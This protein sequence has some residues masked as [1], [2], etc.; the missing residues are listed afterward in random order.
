MNI[1]WDNSIR[2]G[3]ELI[4][5]A[6]NAMARQ[7]CTVRVNGQDVKSVRVES[8][9]YPEGKLL[10]RPVDEEGE[11]N[12]ARFWLSVYDIETLHIY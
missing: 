10:L 6:L 4:W 5:D 2:D 9:R 11:R 3:G 1:T 8:I 7:W 12:G